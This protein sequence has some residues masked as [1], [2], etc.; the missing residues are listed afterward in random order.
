MA[1]I[2]WLWTNDDDDSVDINNP[3]LLDDDEDSFSVVENFEL[4]RNLIH[5][6]TPIQR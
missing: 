6:V 5:K 1:R 2:T 4:D 3:A